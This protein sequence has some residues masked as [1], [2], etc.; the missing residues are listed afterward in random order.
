MTV[1]R[2]RVRRDTPETG[3]FDWAALDAHGAVVDQGSSQR[4]PGRTGLCQLV[5]PSEL[6]L[7]AEVDAPAA[8]QRRLSGALRFLVEDSV[9]PDPERLHVTAGPAADKDRL[10]VAVVDRLWLRSVLARLEEHGFTPVSA[11]AEC[12]LAPVA[13]GG[14]TV[15]W[16]GTEGFARTGTRKAFAL[17]GVAPDGPP[18]SLH[19]AL[20]EERPT[21]I[22]LRLAAGTELPDLQRWSEALGVPIEAGT[23]WL[24]AA[25]AWQPGLELLQGEFAQRNAQRSWSAH[26]RRPA[27][28]AAALVLVSSCGLALDWATK[29]RERRALLGEMQAIY[30][31]TFGDAAVIVDAPLQM[32]RG[33]SELRVRSGGSSLSDFLPL[34]A[35]LTERVLEP[36]RSR[37]ENI[38]FERGTLTASLRPLPGRQA[39]ELADE[40]R[41]R[42]AVPGLSSRVEIVGPKGG[43]SVRITVSPEGGQWTSARR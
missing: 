35:L 17:D 1:W 6:V 14:W 4:L 36:A 23:P 9:I 11:S 40:L 13:P 34:L 33:L 26:L 28:L 3:A 2:I 8:Q 37:I 20:S 16:R 15:V 38:G 21:R 39:A 22:V 25:A 43:E 10:A 29:A 41:G 5:V 19:L 32:Q 30:R 24:W 18:V 12:L 7:L 27:L 31:Q 42:S